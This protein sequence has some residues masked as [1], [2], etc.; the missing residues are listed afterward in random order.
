[1]LQYKKD[2]LIKIVLRGLDKETCVQAKRVYIHYPLW[3]EG[4]LLYDITHG[5]WILFPRRN[6]HTRT[7]DFTRLY[8]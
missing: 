3:Y 1:M 4:K 7:L 6:Y 8:F 5:V 2:M